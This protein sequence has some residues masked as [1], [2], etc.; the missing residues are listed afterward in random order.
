MQAEQPQQ[1]EGFSANILLL[2]FGCMVVQAALSFSLGWLLT[3]FKFVNNIFMVAYAGVLVK[4][5]HQQV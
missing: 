3:T 2:C 5:L 4:A 1:A